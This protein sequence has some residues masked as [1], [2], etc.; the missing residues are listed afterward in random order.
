MLLFLLVFAI[1]L[2]VALASDVDLTITKPLDGARYTLSGTLVINVTVKNEGDNDS[3]SVTVSAEEEGVSIT[4]PPAVD[5][6]AGETAS[7]PL[8]IT[9]QLCKPM[10]LLIKVSGLDLE[11]DAHEEQVLVELRPPT[12][13]L[14]I[15]YPQQVL[16]LVDVQEN[17]TKSF[18]VLVKNNKI[19]GVDG[20][21]LLAEYNAAKINCSVSSGSQSVPGRLTASYSVTCNNVNTGDRVDF[22]LIDSCNIIQ[23]AESVTFEIVPGTKDY[24]L[25]ILSP[26]ENDQLRVSNLGGIV[27]VVVASIGRDNMTGICA[28]VNGMNFTGDSCVNLISEQNHTFSLMVFP[29]NNITNV[30]IIVNDSTGAAHDYVTIWITRIAPVQIANVTPVINQSGQEN[31]TNLSN[32]MTSQQK[33]AVFGIPH[34]ILILIIVLVPI[35]I[36]AVYIKRGRV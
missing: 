23:D 15:V 26:V 13:D 31:N 30:G 24:R 32:V 35:I 29:T 12:K 2:P 4:V 16:K 6:P 25:R 3:Y 7:F 8:T 19:E 18:D 27:D 9:G 14:K 10:P 34:E 20:L 1:M 5:I 33:N 36:L 28:Y 11:G 21:L 17:G 22:Q